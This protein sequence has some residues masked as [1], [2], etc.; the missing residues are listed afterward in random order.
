MKSSFKRLFALILTIVSLVSV[1]TISASAASN[2]P[3]IYYK[4]HCQNVGWTGNSYDGATS[5]TT[6]QSL[7]VEAIQI[8]TSGMSGGI[9]YRTHCQNIGWTGWSSNG[10]TSGT[11]G[12]SLRVEAIQ[13]KLTGTLSQKYDVFYRTHVQNYGWRDWVKNGAT[14]GTT[15][16]SLRVE[17]IQIKLVAKSGA[18]NSN[19]VPIT[20]NSSAESKITARLQSMMNGSYDNN[21]YKVNTT[22]TGPYAHEECKGFAKRI[23]QILFGFNIGSTKGNKYEINYSSN[24][25]I[26]VGTLTSLSDS[27]LRNLF[28]KARPGDFIQVKRNHG[29]P[30]SMIFLSADANGVTVYESNVVAPNYIE[31]KTYEWGQFRS[32]NAAVSV[33]TAKDY[34]LH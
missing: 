21:T 14:S 16:Q 28:N 11:T 23:H 24:N 10:S 5:G 2:S 20:G 15:G 6:G 27:A 19:T 17:A 34:T 33:Y 25:S 22:Y 13:I 1:F 18:S 9:T 4:T 3:R 12:Q 30:H 29:G 32:A 26:K 7:R 8:R 31:K